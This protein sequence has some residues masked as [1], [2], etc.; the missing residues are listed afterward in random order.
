[1]SAAYLLAYDLGT[2]GIKTALFGADGKPVDSLFAE[3]PTL[4][5][6]ESWAE[7][8]PEAWWAAFCA[9]TRELLEKRRLRPGEIA[10]L[11]FSGQMMA[12][13]PVDR[14]GRALRALHHLGRPAQPAAGPGAGRGASTRRPTTGS[15]GTRSTPP[16]LCPSSCG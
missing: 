10:A 15:R 12:C 3:Y 6:E 8:D 9:S 13:L 7:Q 2:G 14:E 16:T 5:A 11:S 1:M 4:S